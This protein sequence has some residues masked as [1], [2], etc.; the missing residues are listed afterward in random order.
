M[1][2]MNGVR[3]CTFPIHKGLA[4]P[5]RSSGVPSKMQTQGNERGERQAAVL[6]SRPGDQASENDDPIN[7]PFERFP[8][9]ATDAS[10]VDRFREI[11]NRFGTARGG[12]RRS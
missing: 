10:V 3:A 2:G 12:G 4:R 7:W 6:L 9:P 5:A 8:P 1:S 11:A